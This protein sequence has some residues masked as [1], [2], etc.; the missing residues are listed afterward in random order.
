MP[1]ICGTTIII[2]FTYPHRSNPV[3]AIQRRIK[4]PPMLFVLSSVEMFGRITRRTE[5]KKVY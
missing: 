4:F 1:L 2:F 3:S 5:T